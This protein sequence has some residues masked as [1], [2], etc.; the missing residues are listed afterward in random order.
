MRAKAEIEEEKSG[1]MQIVVS[2]IPYQVNKEK[3]IEAIAD[4]V[5]DKKIEG[6]SDLRDESN[7]HGMAIVVEL[8]KDADSGVVL[9]QLYKH[10]NLE[11]T[12]SMILLALVDGE[13]KVLSLKDMIVHYVNHQKE[14]VT[15][16]T[17]FDLDKAEARKHILD[18]YIIA[19]DNI[20][21][22]IKIIKGAKDSR[23]A[24]ERLIEKYKL[25]EIQAKAIL[26]MKLQKLTGLERGKIEN[27]IA[28]LMEKIAA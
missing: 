23:T 6:I 20:D 27:E 10:T 28:E 2:E 7:R 11:S 14:I 18:G 1:K 19:L 4:G 3:L 12:F 15:R 17:Q 5:R 8:K 26:D 9:N 22:M 13:P 21:D 24:R 25:T 16:R